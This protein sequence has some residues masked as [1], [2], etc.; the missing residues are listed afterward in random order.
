MSKQHKRNRK[1]PRGYGIVRT[2]NTHGSQQHIQ[3]VKLSDSGI[4][5]SNAVGIIT[6]TIDFNPSTASEWAQFSAI[7]DEFR[8]RAV[9]LSLI[10]YQQGSVTA[11]NGTVVFVFDNDDNSVLTSLGAALEYESDHIIPAVWYANQNKPFS[12]TFARPDAG[13]HT[14]ENWYDVGAPATA[15]GSVKFYS[16]AL[17]TSVTYYT[18]V[19]EYFVEYRDRR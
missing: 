12:A 2:F 6:K 7:Y 13:D 18:Y 14:A 3:R 8:V 4:V 16:T 19:M 1:E 11:L 5:A 10:P 15:V 9:R 17:T